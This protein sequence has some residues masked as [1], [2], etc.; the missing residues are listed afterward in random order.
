MNSDMPLVARLGVRIG[1]DQ[2]GEA[3]ALDAVGDPGLG[4]VDARS[5]RRRARRA[6]RIA[7][8]SVPQSGSVSARPP[9]SSPE[10]KRG[11]KAR[12]C[13]SVPKRS[14]RGRHHQVRVEDAGQR[15]PDLATSRV[16]DAGV[17]RASAGRGRHIRARSSRRTGR[18]RASARPSRAGRRRRARAPSPAAAPRAPAISRSHRAS[19]ARRPR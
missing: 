5:G 18:T 9:R 4:A 16:D 11:R 3:V 17:G 14:H 1:L 19:G 6:V 13:S 15:H 10:A 7:C 8:R 2:Q 12:F